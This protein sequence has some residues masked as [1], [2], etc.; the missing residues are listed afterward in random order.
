MWSAKLG[1]WKYLIKISS[2]LEAR[3]ELDLL[4]SHNFITLTTVKVRAKK[5]R[6]I[7]D[8]DI[9]LFVWREI[10][11]SEEF[12]ICDRSEMNNESGIPMRSKTNRLLFKATF[13][14]K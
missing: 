12:E 4:L 9:V 3:C 7:R 2:L 6:K 10:S 5:I 14:K 8:L 13:N 11:A 1:S